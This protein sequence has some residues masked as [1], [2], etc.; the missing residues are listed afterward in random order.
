M[1]TGAA[2]EDGIEGW[3]RLLNRW[4]YSHVVRAVLSIFVLVAL[5]LAIAI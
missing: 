3:K 2:S 1:K 4:E 5:I